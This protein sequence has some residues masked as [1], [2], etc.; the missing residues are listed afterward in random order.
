MRLWYV[1]SPSCIVTR[2]NEPLGRTGSFGANWFV[3]RKTLEMQQGQAGIPGWFYNSTQIG[4]V[5]KNKQLKSPWDAKMRFLWFEILFVSLLWLRFYLMA[6][7]LCICGKP[8]CGGGNGNRLHT[9]VKNS[10]MTGTEGSTV[11]HLP[12]PPSLTPSIHVP[13]APLPHEWKTRRN[14]LQP[15][16][17]SPTAGW[18][19]S[20]RQLCRW[21]APIVRGMEQGDR[22]LM[23]DGH[24]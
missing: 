4:A 3:P 8:L 17:G 9:G 16:P 1:V 7:M 2:W 12:P 21:D 19:W 10:S 6:P 24:G 23:G 22:V 5:L 18:G 20:S 11:D 15:D 13:M 14:E